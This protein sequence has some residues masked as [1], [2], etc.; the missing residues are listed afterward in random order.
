MNALLAHCPDL[1][2][3]NGVQRPGIVHRLDKDTSGLLVV[4]RTLEAHTALV[5]SL[6]AREVKREYVAI[7]NGVLTG[8]GTVDEPVT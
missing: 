3:I 7:C 1:P 4:A 5:A 2:G 8:G 6:A